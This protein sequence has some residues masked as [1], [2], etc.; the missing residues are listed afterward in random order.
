VIIGMGVV[1]LLPFPR[2]A[3][4]ALAQGA[5]KAK[6]GGNLAEPKTMMP[7]WKGSK[8]RAPGRPS[9]V[10][11]YQPDAAPAAETRDAANREPIKLPAADANE[12]STALIVNPKCGRALVGYWKPPRM[13]RLVMC[14][15]VAG[16]VLGSFTVPTAAVPMA[17]SDNG[18]HI[19]VRFLPEAGAGD[20]CHVEVW[21]WAE[22]G[23]TR[24]V[25]FLPHDNSVQ[26]NER[27]T[28]ATFLDDSRLVTTTTTNH[29]MFW[30]WRGAKLL[31]VFEKFNPY[32]APV[33]SGNRK[34]VYATA[35]DRS[36]AIINSTSFDFAGYHLA[37][38]WTDDFRVHP[39]GSEVLTTSYDA[40]NRVGES[41]VNSLPQD[42]TSSFFQLTPL[43][44][45]RL[46]AFADSTG[47]L[48]ELAEPPEISRPDKGGKTPK[49][50][51]PVKGTKPAEKKAGPFVSS[52]AVHEID[53]VTKDDLGTFVYRIDPTKVTTE[54][55]VWVD[56]AK[57]VRAWEFSGIDRLAAGGADCW[58]LSRT[59]KGK[60]AHLVPLMLPGAELKEQI[61]KAVAEPD[62]YVLKDGGTVKVNLS[63]LPATDRE[64]AL[65][66]LKKQLEQRRV[67]IGEESDIELVAKV[68][69]Y[70]V[71]KVQSLAQVGR[72]ALIGQ[73]THRQLTVEVT[74]LVK[75]EP[76]YSKVF[77]NNVSLRD[78]RPDETAQQYYDR[79]PG[80]PVEILGT[81]GL[82][83]IIFGPNGNKPLGST[84]IGVK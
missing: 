43:G 36:L 41:F 69:P 20:E 6:S 23:L 24:E 39:S 71:R 64:A 15:L 33:V 51:K 32:A 70:Q 16:T 60:P 2:D 27:L 13:T 48:F 65:A 4:Q 74:L 38:G 8:K 40:V 10:E 81:F 62:Y 45:G 29:L 22:K 53:E 66:V 72:S 46:L 25:R 80:T 44:L 82:P 31:Y 12:E 59:D 79:N 54:K 75:G 18:E 83:E 47:A 55:I 50:T 77:T 58:C 26:A 1:P 67:H 78:K 56:L 68:G 11:E 42:R 21:N 17:L 49:T 9:R 63:G 30:E 57:R 61:A 73:Q 28:F 5:G 14:D 3:A 7:A 52:I 19:A 84:N 34:Y 35:D 76:V 37:R